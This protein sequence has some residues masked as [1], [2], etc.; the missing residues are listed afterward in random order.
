MLETEEAQGGLLIDQ[1]STVV[2]AAKPVIVVA[3]LFGAVI[4]P[5]PETF[6]HKPIPT[7]AAFAAIVGFVPTQTV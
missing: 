2:P 5:D 4:A 3:G 7:A 6:T 1:V